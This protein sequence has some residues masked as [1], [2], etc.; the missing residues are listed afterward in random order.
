MV[1]R[2]I[3]L[4]NESGLHMRPAGL[5]VGEANRCRSHVMLIHGE[6]RMNCKS[7]MSILA[8]PVP[9]VDEVTIECDGEDEEQ[10]LER[11]TELI[12]HLE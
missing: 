2:T 5:L 6:H 8:F 12:T 3:V 4:D 9:P 11:I 1:R 10:D 7:L